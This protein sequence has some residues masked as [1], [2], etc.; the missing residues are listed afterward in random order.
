ME[1]KPS[2]FFLIGNQKTIINEKKG[3]VQD[4]HDDE[5]QEKIEQTAQQQKSNQEI[6]LRESINSVIEEQSVKPQQRDHSKRLR[7]HKSFNSPNVFSMSSKERRFRS[8][9]TIHIKHPGTK[10][11]MSELRFPSH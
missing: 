6:K 5:H 4:V 1:L 11:Q 9:H 10:F 2:N 7:W 3:K 8:N